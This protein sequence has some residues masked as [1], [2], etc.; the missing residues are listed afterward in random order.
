MD[1]VQR[2]WQKSTFIK[3]LI[4][5]ELV[6]IAELEGDTI[7]TDNGSTDW[8]ELQAQII[9]FLVDSPLSLD[10]F[11]NSEEK[12]IIDEKD[13]IFVSVID[14]YSVTKL[15]KEEESSDEEKVEEIQP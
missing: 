3:K 9:Q 5:E 12:I 10:E 13:N 2:Y 1:I 4:L 7:I 15:S 8:I 14:Y 11:L 6:Q